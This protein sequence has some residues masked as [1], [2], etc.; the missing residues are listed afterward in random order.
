MVAAA[1]LLARRHPSEYSFLP[2]CPLAK[3]AH[4]YC[5]GCG[6]TRAIH[7]LLNLEIA[8]AWRHN[9]ALILIGVPVLACYAASLVLRVLG[10][11]SP[12]VQVPAPVVWALAAGLVLYGIAR[13]LPFPA[14]DCIRPPAASAT[15]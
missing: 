13:N 3:Y 14:L 6:S 2:P 9:P 5:P 11:R 15:A 10:V 7:F 8:Q 4:L 1:I 12:T